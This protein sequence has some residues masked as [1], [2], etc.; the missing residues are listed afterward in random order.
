M[1]SD[2][3][4]CAQAQRKIPNKGG[5]RLFWRN[6]KGREMLQE[7]GTCNGGKSPTPFNEIV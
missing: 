6:K 5:T 7:G 4:A 2:I 3:I 1:T